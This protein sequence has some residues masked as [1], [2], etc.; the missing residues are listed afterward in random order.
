MRACAQTGKYGID[1]YKKKRNVFIFLQCT[2]QCVSCVFNV[3]I[4]NGSYHLGFLNTTVYVAH[5]EDVKGIATY[6]SLIRYVFPVLRYVEV[7]HFFN[8]NM[9][10]MTYS[11][12]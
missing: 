12:L 11:T 5:L 1:F 8:K 2:L 10:P 4:L 6:E 3:G 9:N 7:I